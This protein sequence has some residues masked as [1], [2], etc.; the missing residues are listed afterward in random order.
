MTETIFKP[1]QEYRTRDGRRARVYA[2][3]G[4]WD[5]P[6]HGAIWFS[7]DDIW[8][9]DSWAVSGHSYLGEGSD[10][11]L[12]PPAPEPKPATVTF[13]INFREGDKIRQ[14]EFELPADCIR[15]PDD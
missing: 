1:G 11:D 3:D 7:G 4:G 10:K 15:R 8:E 9:P 12:M 5:Y 6:V 2:T 13:T 14:Y